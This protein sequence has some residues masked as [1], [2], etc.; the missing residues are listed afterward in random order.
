[1]KSYEEINAKIESKKAVVLTAEDIIGY[2]E[3]KGLAAAARE[4]D[5]V[6]TATFGPMCSSGCFLNFDHSK[7]A[8]HPHDPGVDRRG[9]RGWSC[10]RSPTAPTSIPCGSSAPPST[11]ATSIRPSGCAVQNNPLSCRQIYQMPHAYKYRLH[12]APGAKHR[13]DDL[14]TIEEG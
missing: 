11:S 13:P 1:M 3:K 9:A 8:P 14:A 7:E 4:V 12:S 5:V 10:T 6:T 2:V